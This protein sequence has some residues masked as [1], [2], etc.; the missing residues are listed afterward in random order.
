MKRALF[1]RILV[2]VVLVGI[3]GVFSAC[4]PAAAPAPAPTQAPAATAQAPKPG[5]EAPKPAA[6]PSGTEVKIGLINPFTAPVLSDYG[7]RDRIAVNIAVKEVN[8]AGGINGVPLKVVEE[9]EVNDQATVGLVR[10]LASDD[11]VLVII[12]PFS[13]G[14]IPLAYPQAVAAKTPIITSSP[15]HG[16]VG[17]DNAPWG[18][19]WGNPNSK[20]VSQTIQAFIKKYNLKKVGTV[21]PSDQA[22]NKLMGEQVV[23]EF[24]AQGVQVVDNIIISMKDTDFTAAVTRLKSLNVDGV[25]LSCCSAT[26]GTFVS[27]MRRQAV[28][29]PVGGVRML[30]EAAYIQTGGKAVEGTVAGVDFWEL[31]PDPLQAQF[32]QAFQAQAKADFP[33]NTLIDAYVGSNYDIVRAIAKVMKDGGITNAP[34]DLAKDRETI[35]NGLQKLK[36][37]PSVGGSFSMGPDGQ[38]DR[39]VYLL[40]V[41][42]GKY[43]AL[44]Q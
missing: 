20:M 14:A 32:S 24:K 19:S 4:A 26:M 39:P 13:G 11:K 9:D 22:S 30:G 37:F 34:A 3:L 1:W 28:T 10:K 16:T 12:G 8:A 18:F 17:K 6:K 21:Y 33:K 44:G 2:A 31:N 23:D 35:M 29:I 36:N 15:M 43:Q 42:D 27:E 5:A 38:V 7:Q 40:I 25:S 41:K